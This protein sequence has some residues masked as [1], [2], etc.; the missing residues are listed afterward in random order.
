MA[1]LLL[2]GCED[3]SSLTAGGAA[4]IVAGR[5]QNGIRLTS[6]GTTARYQPLTA[7]EADAATVGFAFRWTI[8]SATA[9]S[10][11][12]LNSDAAATQHTVVRLNVDGSISVLRGATVLFTTA[13][14]LV[15]ANVWYYLELQVRLS[16]TLG[17]VT[18]RLNGA[19]VGSQASGDTK[20][21]GTKTVY[22]TVTWVG[23][24][25]ST[26]DIDDIYFALATTTADA[27]LG[28]ITVETL[29]PDGNGA[30]SGWAGSDGD[31]TNNYQLVDEPN[32]VNDLDYVYAG[33]VGQQDLYSLANLVH[34][35]GTI[36][37]LC[38]SARLIRTD[39]ATPMNVKLLNHRVV[40]TKSAALP[41]AATAY[42]S[43]EYTLTTDPETGAAFTIA[44]VNALQTGVELA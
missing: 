23:G 18:L 34:T 30:V 5:Y 1:L 12:S 14:A 44:N 32:P 26:V 15:A 29:L 9:V 40:D 7:Q 6:T 38:H 31:S 28:G 4:A 41:L 24:T 33:T 10:I 22:D 17:A 19:T 13:L 3:F 2:D 25:S 37:A 36:V 35:S 20:N 11:L 27:F 21:A 39:T 43:Y 8:Q 16:D 42:R